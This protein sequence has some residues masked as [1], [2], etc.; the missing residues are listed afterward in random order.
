[1][2]V[3]GD[4][5][6]S[7]AS[8]PEPIEHLDVEQPAVLTQAG[9]NRPEARGPE[10][11]E[12]ALRVMEAEVEEPFDERG[13]GASLDVPEQRALNRPSS[14][15]HA[16]PADGIFGRG[17]KQHGHAPELPGQGRRRRRR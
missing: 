8:G 4:L 11:L 16:R 13:E 15:L 9:Q 14:H 12:A 3:D 2:A 17:R 1:M 6:E 10:E 7:G 5:G